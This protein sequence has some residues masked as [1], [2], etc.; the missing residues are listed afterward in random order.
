MKECKEHQ[1]VLDWLLDSENTNNPFNMGKNS[2]F[3]TTNN[4]D[5]KGRARI[6]K[7]FGKMREVFNKE[8]DRLML[9]GTETDKFEKAKEMLKSREPP[10][11][12]VIWTGKEWIV[13]SY[14]Q[15][16]KNNSK[17]GNK[18]IKVAS[19]HLEEMIKDKDCMLL[20]P[21]FQSKGYTELASEKKIFQQIISL[22]QRMVEHYDNR[23]EYVHASLENQMSLTES[24]NGTIKKNN[25]K[26]SENKIR[27]IENSNI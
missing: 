19:K 9:E 24:K 25:S 2:E 12:Y 18:Y 20:S 8:Q 14:D 7:F 27:N 11:F 17:I 21:D 22:Y 4:I 5:E 6:A 3:V 16:F 10:L 26:I 15:K 13:P 1:I 23:M